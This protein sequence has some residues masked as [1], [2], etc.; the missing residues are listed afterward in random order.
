MYPGSIVMAL[1][2]E[3]PTEGSNSLCELLAEHRKWTR[4][5]VLCRS[6]ARA[7]V[8]L[9][10]PS[11]AIPPAL[12]GLVMAG[13]GSWLE[14]FYG[15]YSQAC[16]GDDDDSNCLCIFLDRMAFDVPISLGTLVEHGIDSILACRQCTG[17]A[18]AADNP[19]PTIDAKSQHIEFTCASCSKRT[20]R[21]LAF[22]V[23]L[24]KR[25]LELVPPFPE[26]E[27]DSSD[28]PEPSQTGS[29]S[30]TES[31]DGGSPAG[32]RK[33]KKRR[34]GGGRRKRLRGDR[35]FSRSPSTPIPPLMS[36]RNAAPLSPPDLSSPPVEEKVNAGPCGDP[37]PNTELIG[38]AGPRSSEFSPNKRRRIVIDVPSSPLGPVSL[39]PNH[40][41]DLTPSQSSLPKRSLGTR[42]REWILRVQLQEKTQ[43]PATPSPAE[44]FRTE[45]KQGAPPSRSSYFADALQLASEDEED[46]LTP[47]REALKSPT[48][49][50]NRAMMLG[51]SNAACPQIVMAMSAMATENP[52]NSDI[53]GFQLNETNRIR[54]LVN[55]HIRFLRDRDQVKQTE[56]FLEH[57]TNCEFNT[58]DAECTVNLCAWL[59]GRVLTSTQQNRNLFF[60]AIVLW[61]SLRPRAPTDAICAILTQ[62]AARKLLRPSHV[63][64]WVRWSPRPESQKQM[65]A[66]YFEDSMSGYDEDDGAS[67][68]G[69]GH[70]VLVTTANVQS[71]STASSSDPPSSETDPNAAQNSGTAPLIPMVLASEN[72]DMREQWREISGLSSDAFDQFVLD[73]ARERDGPNSW[74]PINIFVLR[75]EPPLPVEI[76]ED[77]S[78]SAAAALV[79]LTNSH[80]EATT[81]TTNVAHLSRLL[82]PIN[83]APAAPIQASRPKRARDES[84]YSAN[85]RKKRRLRIKKAARHRIT[86]EQ[87]RQ[88]RRDSA[89]FAR[90][91]SMSADDENDP[92]YSSE[93]ETERYGTEEEDQDGTVTEGDTERE[94]GSDTDTDRASDDNMSAEDEEPEPPQPDLWGSEGEGVATAVPTQQ[95]PT[96]VQEPEED[97]V[98]VEL[99][100]PSPPFNTEPVLEAPADVIGNVLGLV[101]PSAPSSQS[102]HSPT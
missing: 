41:P 3:S 56:F 8:P 24:V 97:D 57:G 12:M 102:H 16:G 79:N 27:P 63:Q 39:M 100:L 40:A 58:E 90:H 55:G 78:R 11:R 44:P 98:S 54:L 29:D 46:G 89:A 52:V 84:P 62:C 87:R 88:A 43:E 69:K 61:V 94:K 49:Y 17:S 5:R 25:F 71:G 101:M 51:Q 31:D 47:S 59:I 77:R 95:T 13:I 34:E 66:K 2:N 4:L 15:P 82:A 91:M 96:Q 35:S 36:L 21:P 53:I 75:V 6:G 65:H 67:E 70:E 60:S 93:S 42:I 85:E 99:V 7:E 38:I 73:R 81:I 72:N 33:R 32:R 1:R 26:P 23:P 80:S 74:L 20:R 92:D 22:A 86:K 48:E 68:D 30:E 10:K 83:P 14:M 45:T 18:M 37:T 64:D 9:D 50:W 28:G 76:G 19:S